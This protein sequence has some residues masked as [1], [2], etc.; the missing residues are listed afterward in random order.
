MIR[1]ITS[2]AVGIAIAC[3]GTSAFAQDEG[4]EEAPA[5]DAAPAGEAAGGDAA[6]GGGAAASASTDALPESKGAFGK[7]GQ[8]AISQDLELKFESRT[9]KSP[10]PPDGTG[11]DVKT[12]TITIGPALDYFV[13]DSISIGGKIQYSNISSDGGDGSLIGIGP[14]VGYNLG[15]TDNISLWPK[16]SFVYA[17]TSAEADSPGAEEIKGTK[18]TVGVDAPILFH[19]APHFFIGLGPYFELDLSSKAKVG[20]GDSVDGPKDTAFGV[21]TVVGGWF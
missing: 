5:G 6:A 7:S 19:P 15:L 21:R 17:M 13:A 14:R 1:R 18:M 2:L 9:S 3:F 4:G 20:D 8:I 16:L 10:D 12:T 11:E